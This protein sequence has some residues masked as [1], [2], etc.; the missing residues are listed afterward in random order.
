MNAEYCILAD[1]PYR[2]RNEQVNIGLVVLRQDGVRV[3]LCDNLRKVKALNP[4]A[5]LDAVHDWAE[6]LP[7][8]LAGC[9]SVDAARQALSQWGRDWALEGRGSF[10]YDNE[11]QYSH[12]VKMAIDNLVRP[13]ARSGVAR[14]PISRL[15]LDLKRSFALNGWLG[16]DINAHQIV[17]RYA[18]GPEVNAEFAL[19]NGRL[20]VIESIDLRTENLSA[21][22]VELRAKALVLDMAKRS[23]QGDA[24]CYAVMAGETSKIA[25]DT[26]ELLDIYADHVFQWEHARD[27][28]SLFDILGAATGKPR[29]PMPPAL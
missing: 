14:E 16:K 6:K 27:I 1:R 4:R 20:N 12:R 21:K 7:H 25:E 2:N 5:N 19:I 29:I 8:L 22:R 28:D 17:T 11:D 24:A 3:H 26:R 10:A 18:V 23:R 15:H 13:S 9:L